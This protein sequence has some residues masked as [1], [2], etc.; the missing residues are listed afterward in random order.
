MSISGINF[1]GCVHN[2][3]FASETNDGGAVNDKQLRDFMNAHSEIPTKERTCD[4]Q[5]CGHT[6][7]STSYW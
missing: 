4:A 6:E 2:Y 7:N 1:T 3:F 5:K